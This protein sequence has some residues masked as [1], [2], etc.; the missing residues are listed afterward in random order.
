MTKAMRAFASTRPAQEVFE[1]LAT[2]AE[3]VK[4]SRHFGEAATIPYLRRSGFLPRSGPGGL[5]CAELG[6]VRCFGADAGS[7][8]ADCW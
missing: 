2:A 8:S 4:R 7:A 3:T 5:P 1:F 6:P